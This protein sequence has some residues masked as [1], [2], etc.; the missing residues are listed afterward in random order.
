MLPEGGEGHFFCVFWLL[1]L[2]HILIPF[3]VPP[4]V[5]HWRVSGRSSLGTFWFNFRC[6]P[7]HR[8]DYHHPLHLS[9]LQQAEDVEGW[10]LLPCF[11]EYVVDSLNGFCVP[12]ERSSNLRILLLGFVLGLHIKYF[13]TEILKILIYIKGLNYLASSKRIKWFS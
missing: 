13:I 8:E 11:L 6:P 1:P 7:L 10:P 2:V 9:V 3:P 4:S 5:L 12:F